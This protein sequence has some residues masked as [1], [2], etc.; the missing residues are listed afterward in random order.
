[1]LRPNSLANF[2]HKNVQVFHHL[3]YKLSLSGGLRTRNGHLLVTSGGEAC[4]F[5]G[6][7]SRCSEVFATDLLATD[8]GSGCSTAPEVCCTVHV[9]RCC[10]FNGLRLFWLFGDFRVT[11]QHLLCVPF[12][13]LR[14]SNL[15][16][17]R[18]WAS[19]G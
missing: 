5:A 10:S 16:S 1:M 19:F 12:P 17:V 11:S 18:Y 9:R 8:S 3:P 7:A 2:V 6:V 4:G 13:K 15:N 14:R